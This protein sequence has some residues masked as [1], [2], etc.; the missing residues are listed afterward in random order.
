MHVPSTDGVQVAVHDLGGLGPTLLISHATGF[1][2]QCYAAL[3]GEL[4]SDAHCV[5][6]DYRGH[7]DTAH[8]DGVEVS[9][10]RSADDAI[11]VAEWVEPDVCFGHSMGGTCLLLAAARRPE[12]FPRLVL[13]EP[14]VPPPHSLPSG[15]DNPLAAGALRRRA[16][17]PSYQEAIDN[18]AAK[19][20]LNQFRADALHAYVHH[21]F[22]PVPGGGVT[23]K[24]TPQLEAETFGAGAESGAFELLGE[25]RSEV[26]VLAGRRDGS[27]PPELAD[28]VAEGLDHAELR[29]IDQFDHF[30]PMSHPVEFAA[31]I[32]AWLRR[33]S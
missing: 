9:W 10:R 23:L 28:A 1:H 31:E 6:F 13:F 20:P 15:L 4:V 7:G 22:R 27:P 18:F 16:T 12:L 2:G 19:P 24:C 33:T 11:A 8:P 3:A 21:G 14:I 29:R 17:F 5:A 32:R 25:I 26:L 30:A